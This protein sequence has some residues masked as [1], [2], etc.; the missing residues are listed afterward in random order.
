MVSAQLV[1]LPIL[2]L[3][4]L[5]ELHLQESSLVEEFPVLV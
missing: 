1:A 5:K 4:G 3:L 2:E